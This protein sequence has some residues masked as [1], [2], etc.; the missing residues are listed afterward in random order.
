MKLNYDFSVKDVSDAYDTEIGI[1]WEV[2]MGEHIH[3]GGEAETKRLAEKIG[4]DASTY[5]LDVCS[6]LGGPAR[7]LASTYNTKIVGIDITETMI[8]KSIERTEK[9]GLADLIE[10][11]R[12]NALDIP[13]KSNTFD[14]V[15]GQDAW[16]YITSK[17]RLIKEIVRV[18]KPGGTIGFTDW[19]LGS[20]PISSQE[21]ADFLFEFMLFPNMETLEGYRLL[22]ENNNCKVLEVEDLQEDFAKHMHIYKEKLK[23]LKDEIIENFNEQLYQIA[24][25]GVQAW[26]KAA[27]DGKVSRGLWLAE[28]L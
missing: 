24:E 19:I 23:G 11:R 1:L 10:F 16:C 7:F 18:C 4:I 28:K 12:G 2:L 6:A 9:A 21:E 27:N 15:W 13:A 17:V 26:T 25:A 3:V 5:L 14:V 20:T 22:L 8:K